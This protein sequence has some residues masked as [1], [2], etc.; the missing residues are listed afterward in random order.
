MIVKVGIPTMTYGDLRQV[1]HELLDEA[2]GELDGVPVRIRAEG[3]SMLRTVTI[4]D[5]HS[6]Y[7]DGRE[8]H[9]IIVLSGDIPL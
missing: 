3:L 5:G 1:L 7:T 9:R 8:P 6:D 2:D 4:E